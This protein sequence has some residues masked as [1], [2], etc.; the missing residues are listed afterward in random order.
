MRSTRPL[1][2]AVTAWLA[3]VGVLVHGASRIASLQTRGSTVPTG[4]VK[5]RTR[6]PFHGVSDSCRAQIDAVYDPALSACGLRGTVNLRANIYASFVLSLV[7]VCLIFALLLRSRGTGLWSLLLSQVRLARSLCSPNL[8]VDPRAGA[9]ASDR[10]PVLVHRTDGAP[11]HPSRRA[12]WLTSMAQVLISLNPNGASCAGPR[13]A[14][15]ML[16]PR[17]QTR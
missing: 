6:R 1:T 17:T 2:R 15:G 11:A 16:T 13:C 8:T 7:S 14:P 10:D 4:V 12:A 3:E 9:S 5:V